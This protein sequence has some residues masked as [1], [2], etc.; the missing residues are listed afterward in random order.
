MI[1]VSEPD[2]PITLQGFS[3]L[4]PKGENWQY[5][6]PDETTIFFFKKGQDE[7]HT[8]V[9]RA[10]GAILPAKSTAP[11]ENFLESIR[12]EQLEQQ[13]KT[14][15]KYYDNEFAL[16]EEKNTLCVR[17]HSMWKDYASKHIPESE[18][19]LVGEEIGLVCRHPDKNNTYNVGVFLVYSQRAKEADLID[20]RE[21]ADYFFQ[22]M[23]FEPL[24]S[25]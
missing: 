23:T 9:V 15:Y 18:P 3:V 8:F 16:T 14:K 24:D 5:V 4:P 21:D 25:K 20:I 7:T 19:Y 6:K 11:K 1:K 12:S 2:K 17:N 13:S 22:N 10:Q